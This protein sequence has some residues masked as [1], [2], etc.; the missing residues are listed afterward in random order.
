MLA[1]LAAAA[2]A[3]AAG[4]GQQGASPQATTSATSAAGAPA[5]DY[6][7]KL[8]TI[9]SSVYGEVKKEAPIPA[10]RYDDRLFNHTGFREWLLRSTVL[11]EAVSGPAPMSYRCGVFVNHNYKLIFIRNR[12]AAS[13]TVL[14]TFKVA[15]KSQSPLLC[16]KPFSSEDM[17]AH[18]ITHDK[19]WMEYYVVSSTRNPWARA[20]SGFDYTQDRWVMTHG[21]RKGAAGQFSGA[22]R[23][24]RRNRKRVKHDAY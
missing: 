8:V 4:Q 2:L 15:C 3:V 14:D 13:T 1:L 22:G 23:N 5:P 20:A 10:S 24:R 12:K 18:G 7:S 19:M 21:A 11:N 9:P 6:F 17:A 16:M